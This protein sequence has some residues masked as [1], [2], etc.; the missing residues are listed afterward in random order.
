M[1]A[2]LVSLPLFLSLL[3]PLLA[4]KPAATPAKKPDAAAVKQ[5]LAELQTEWAKWPPPL[6]TTALARY[7]A[8]GSPEVAVALAH[9]L[10]DPSAAQ[11]Q[12]IA[13][14]LGT[15]KEPN[16][17][18]TLAAAMAREEAA[19]KPDLEVFASLCK[20]LGDIGDPAAIPA[21]VHHLGSGDRQKPE[22]LTK[23]QARL[24]ALGSIRHV[25]AIDE[26]VDQLGRTGATSTGR[27]NAGNRRVGQILARTIEG[28][29]RRLTG[30]DAEGEKGWRD[31]WRSHRATFKF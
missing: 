6:R 29:L 23:A 9:K 1:R 25:Q 22:W 31:W 11:R 3:G 10:N 14:A 7:V 18:P 24:E 28:S 8:L 20:A 16:T 4:Q 19:P 2:R 12:E 26:L 30:A 17:I 15:L 21:L 5:A 27:G 13:R